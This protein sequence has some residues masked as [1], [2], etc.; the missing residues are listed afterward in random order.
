MPPQ[1]TVL[2]KIPEPPLN[3]LIVNSNPKPFSLLSSSLNGRSYFIDESSQPSAYYIENSVLHFSVFHGNLGSMPIGPISYSF[4]F[5]DNYI[6][7]LKTIKW[8]LP[9]DDIDEAAFI[10]RFNGLYEEWL[11]ETRFD[12][13]IGNPYHKCYNKIVRLR[14]RAVPYIITKLKEAPSLIFVA[15][16]RITGENPVKEENRGIVKKMAEDWIDWWEKK[17]NAR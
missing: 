13:F 17:N 6:G 16:L 10:S 4:N 5:R 12:S 8:T 1:Y 7:R 11:Q 14:E 3:S 2:A 15:L 9:D